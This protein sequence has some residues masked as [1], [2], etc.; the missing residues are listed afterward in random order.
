MR[1]SVRVSVN[2]AVGDH[3]L[4]CG[5]RSSCHRHCLRRKIPTDLPSPLWPLSSR[6]SVCHDSL[7]IVCAAIASRGI[8]WPA[9]D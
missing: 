5:L 1:M 7:A 3:E 9:D 2:V 6:R 8:V 4:C